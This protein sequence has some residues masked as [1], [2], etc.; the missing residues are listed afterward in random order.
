MAL[1]TDFPNPE[2][3][4]LGGQS[5]GYVYRTV[6]SGAT[7]A[8]SFEMLR[9]FLKEEGYG[10]VPLPGNVAELEMFRLPTRNRQILLFEDNG[11]V[12]NPIKILFPN[13][14]K[15]KKALILEV[16]NEAAPQHLLRFHGKMDKR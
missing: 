1:R 11:Y 7:L 13:H 8:A 3:E 16:Y 15:Q 2:T 12:H 5:D 10:D 14:G 4:Y 6:F 9:Q